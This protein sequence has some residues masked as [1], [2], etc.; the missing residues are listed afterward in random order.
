MLKKYI[1]LMVGLVF[2]Y[3]CGKYIKPEDKPAYDNAVNSMAQ[4]EKEIKQTE[5]SENK[6]D[7]IDLFNTAKADL[8]T[9]NDYLN[10]GSYAKAIE[11]AL[12]ASSEAREVRELPTIVSNLIDETEK[13]IRY[14][15]ELGLDKTYGKKIKEVN[16]LLYDTRNYVR[17]KKYSFAKNFGSQAL[18]GIKK[19]LDEVE[20]A[21]AELTRAK[22]ALVEAKEA[23]ADVSA[24]EL[25]K[26]AEEALATAKKEMD[27]NNFKECGEAAKK[28]TQL[29]QE[30]LKK[31]KE[32]K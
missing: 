7:L 15:K 32:G 5:S 17:L 6:K 2:L 16:D 26:S 22:T 11:L 13:S 14:A 29:A 18:D 4:A 20:K 9:A 27:N 28:S 30:S 3:S 21:T 31:A 25:Y 12:K 1:C 8:A 10:K 23:G 19:A 24:S